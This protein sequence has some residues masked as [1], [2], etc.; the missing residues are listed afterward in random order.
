VA[1]WVTGPLGMSD[2]RFGVTD[3][4][5][6]VVPYKDG[7]LPVRM[8][9][10]DTVIGEDGSS[11]VFSL[12]RIHQ[13]DAPLSGGAGMAGTADDVLKLLEALRTGDFL[14]PG[15]R[16]MALGNCIPGIARRPKDAGKGFGFLGAVLSDPVA[17]RTAMPRGAVDWGG[18]W[19][20]NWVIDPGS[21]TVIVT[22]TN[23]TFEGCNGPFRE[24]MNV[25]VFGA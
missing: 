17:A 23:T 21:G 22:C 4:G 1:K 11:T 9:E 18:A 24:E 14:S 3:A 15:L 19:G 8:T 20:H 10:P 7:R 13:K 5:R 16:E 6:L 12:E 25:A 2:A